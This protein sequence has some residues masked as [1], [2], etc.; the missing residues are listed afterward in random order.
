MHITVEA[1]G[2]GWCPAIPHLLG[3]NVVLHIPP[4]LPQLLLHRRLGGSHHPG[5]RPHQPLEVGTRPPVVRGEAVAGAVGGAGARKGGAVGGM[6]SCRKASGRERHCA[7][8]GF[9]WHAR[10]ARLTWAGSTG[11]R[12]RRCIRG[13]QGTDAQSASGASTQHG[14]LLLQSLRQ[15][16]SLL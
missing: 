13:Q 3:G 10:A 7:G 6:C 4:A 1:A 2:Q 14:P 12:M 11:S 5:L 15:Q 8:C 9:H 16:A